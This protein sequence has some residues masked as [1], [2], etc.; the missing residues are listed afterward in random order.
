MKHR[1]TQLSPTTVR[2]ETTNNKKIKNNRP[3]ILVIIR[4]GNK[5]D[6]LFH[7]NKGNQTIQPTTMPCSD[8]K[9]MTKKRRGE[10]RTE[11]NIRLR[12]RA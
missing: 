9:E 6:N 1:Q 12:R 8:I 10:R 3:W 7:N 11:Q 2:T 4:R 5:R